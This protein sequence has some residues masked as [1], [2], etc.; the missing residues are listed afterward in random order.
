MPHEERGRRRFDGG[1]YGL[2]NGTWIV[3]QDA[4]L[5]AVIRAVVTLSAGAA[6]GPLL[7]L[8]TER[9]IATA[10]DVA[11]GQLPMAA[12]TLPVI[13]LAALF[14]LEILETVVRSLA[15]SRIEAG[16]RRGFRADLTEKR[17]RLE[18]H[19]IESQETWDLLRRVA[20]G[21]QVES[22]PAPERGPV[23]QAFDD[24]IGL[25][26]IAVRVIGIAAVL[27]RLGWWILPVAVALMVLYV[28]L[29]IRGGRRLYE[30]ERRAASRRRRAVYLSD[31][32]LQAREAA[33]ER[34]LFGYANY[35]N[36]RW[37]AVYVGVVRSIVLVNIRNWI[38]Y[39]GA[40]APAIALVIAAMLALLRPLETGVIDVAFYVASTMA[41]LQAERLV[42]QELVHITSRL[43]QHGEFFVDLTAFSAMAET[44][45]PLTR[46]AP[47][48][49][50]RSIE[51]V[52]VSFTYPGTEQPV[53][54]DVSVVLEAGQHYA[55]VGANGSGK[56]TIAKLML[57]LY[58]PDSGQILINGTPIAEWS[59]DALN[60]LFGV[61]FQDF[62][63]YSLTVRDNIEVAVPS[64]L[65]DAAVK[66]SLARAG[67]SDDFVRR[68]S[69][70]YDTPLGKVLR[71]G[72]DVSGGEWQRLAMARSLAGDSSVRILDE[73]TAA[74]DPLAESE[75]Y[76]S[77]SSAAT[78][79]TTLFISHRLG[80]TKIADRILVVDGGAIVESGT[81]E[82]LMKHDGLYAQMFTAQRH[83]YETG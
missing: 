73:P 49:P 33:S 55:L 75:L 19:Y 47:E 23:K 24:G 79:L 44:P 62:A 68:L 61:V 78:G 51:F 60:G 3:F 32:V 57:G 40:A 38:R 48:E 15:D 25:A 58:R 34:G 64:R 59:Q 81:H 77:Y 71:G 11:G 43:S 46:R 83:W 42:T 13:A 36:A 35:L 5:A 18:Y 20:A 56:S 65:S 37:R 54:R 30:F 8:A 67:L 74:L 21:P 26:A 72:V 6:T 17:A 28:L 80:S 2:L 29:G 1:H 63:R 66:A 50:F 7:V 69:R 53:L 39:K 70:G 41:L 76:Q 9:F 12:I 31:E 27:A 14:A 4:P 82:E 10:L 45:L 16:L 22:Q 52:G